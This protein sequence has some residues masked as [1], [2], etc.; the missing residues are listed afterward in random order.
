MMLRTLSDQA[1]L[2]GIQ[3]LIRD[4]RTCTLRVLLHLNEI[5][6]RRLH[7]K[8]A[9]T[10]M[11]DYCT[12]GLGYS[13]SAASRR[14]RAARCLARF[15]EVYDLLESNRA[16]ISTL[17]QIS[18][19]LSTDNRTALLARIQGQSQRQVEA[20]VAE[21]APRAAVP[22]DRVS[23]VVVPA[24][25]QAVP[26]T[27]SVPESATEAALWSCTSGD[28]HNRSGC[29]PDTSDAGSTR[30][31]EMTGAT[32]M[33]KRKLV[34]FCASEGFM[35]KVDQVK[36]LVWHRLP[37]RASLEQVFEL[38]LDLVISREDPRARK[39]RREMRA[40]TPSPKPTAPRV[41]QQPEKQVDDLSRRIPAVVRDMVYTRDEGRCAFTGPGGKRCASTTALQVDH[42]KP[43]ARGGTSSPDNLRLLCAYHN[44]LEAERLLGPINRR[45]PPLHLRS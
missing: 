27:L 36:S 42:I 31:M 33:E 8:L 15:P 10:S 11:F 7:L 43:F 18:R 5:E 38:A 30:P 17:A 19:V 21:F 44:R 39:L 20:I 37:A 16:N 28:N 4:E 35:N 14:I 22:R 1:L 13:E 24:P 12:S 40:S 34:Q 25:A 41:E 3:K 2:S 29:T 32:R 9:Y 6:R 45:D 23:T 26:L